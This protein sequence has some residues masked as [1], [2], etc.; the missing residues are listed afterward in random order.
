M[1]DTSSDAELV[2]VRDLE[3]LADRV[4]EDWFATELY[5]ALAGRRLRR[6]D[7]SGTVVN[8]SWRRAEQVV[9]DLRQ[10]A[11]AQ[12]LALAQT[13]GEGEVS[14]DVGRALSERG[15]STAPEDP[16]RRDP[17]HQ[18]AAPSPPPRPSDT[19]PEWEQQAH[20]D[21][22]RERERKL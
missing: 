18:G 16:D 15:W 2:L 5:R 13:G 21:A 22:H 7:G 10:A 12:P 19:A 14:D 6:R 3:G 11:G 20:E 8:L 9:G 4:R 1:A 17:A